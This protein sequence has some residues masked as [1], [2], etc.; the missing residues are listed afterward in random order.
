MAR[1]SD[2]FL[3]PAD[4]GWSWL[5][6]NMGTA[7]GQELGGCGAAWDALYRQTGFISQH[8]H[9]RGDEHVLVTHKLFGSTKQK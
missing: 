6:Q 2:V 4:Q 9:I 5:V 1:R 3:F 8:I 7:P